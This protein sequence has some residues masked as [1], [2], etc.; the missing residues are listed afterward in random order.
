M[1]GFISLLHYALESEVRNGSFAKSGI[2][3]SCLVPSNYSIRGIMLILI[4][5]CRLIRRP[6]Q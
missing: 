1:A 6:L 5:S 2:A 4:A 3:R